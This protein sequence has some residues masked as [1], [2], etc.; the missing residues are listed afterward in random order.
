MDILRSIIY[1]KRGIDQQTAAVFMSSLPLSGRTKRID[2]QRLEMLPTMMS[3]LGLEMPSA[4]WLLVYSVL[5]VSSALP[6]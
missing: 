6:F 3:L 1:I 5:G 2:T 4:V